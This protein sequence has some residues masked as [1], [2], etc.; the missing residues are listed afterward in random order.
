MRETKNLTLRCEMVRGKWED[1]LP[2][3]QAVAAGIGHVHPQE[4]R[5]DGVSRQI[6]LELS[7]GG[8]RRWALSVEAFQAA[9]AKHIVESPD[10]VEIGDVTI[11]AAREAGRPMMIRYLPSGIPMVSAL[12][13]DR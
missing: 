11:P 5:I 13:I 7:A 12:E 3:F 9:R 2:R 10:D 1:P 8:Q 4:D 6:P